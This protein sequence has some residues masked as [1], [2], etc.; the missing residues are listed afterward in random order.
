M[1]ENVEL[2]GNNENVNVNQT[3]NKNKIYIW[4]SETTRS[5]R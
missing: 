5:T 3:I 1:L 4:K 2:D